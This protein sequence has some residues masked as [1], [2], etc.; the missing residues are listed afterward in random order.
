M[1]FIGL[2]EGTLRVLISVK[3]FEKSIQRCAM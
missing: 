1:W 2:P 3:L